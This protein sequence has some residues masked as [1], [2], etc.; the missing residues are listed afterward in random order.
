MNAP[1]HVGNI[2]R[3]KMRRS[4]ASGRRGD[5][6]RGRQT[7]A[8]EASRLSGMELKQRLV[9]FAGELGFDSCRVAACSLPTHAG[10]FDDWLSEGAHGEMD[11]M[12][13]GAEKRR[14]PQKILGG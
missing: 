4:P 1:G 12:A 3:E 13:R 14:D 8:P 6:R 5:L 9:D 10:E 11:Y 7:A 2:V